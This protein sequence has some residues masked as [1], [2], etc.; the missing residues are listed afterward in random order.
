MTDEITTY[1]VT[2]LSMLADVPLRT[3]RITSSRDWWTAR[4]GPSAAR[5]ICRG[6]PGN[7][8]K[9]ESGIVRA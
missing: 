6:I 8:S 7:C 1:T 9:S 2:D 5:A 3:I 4:K